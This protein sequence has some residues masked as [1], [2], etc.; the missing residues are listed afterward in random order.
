M[1]DSAEVPAMV[2]TSSIRVGLDRPARLRRP[3]LLVFVAL[4]AF[5][6]APVLAGSC[7]HSMVFLPQAVLAGEWWRLLTAVLLLDR[8]LRCRYASPGVQQVFGIHHTQFAGKTLEE[9]GLPVPHVRLWEDAVSGVFASGTSREMMV[10]HPW[11]GE[12]AGW[13]LSPVHTDNYVSSGGWSVYDPKRDVFW[14]NGGSGGRVF[15]AF[16]PSDVG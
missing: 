6:N 10:R 14:A 12:T 16:D 7:F 9:A 11:T 1:S 15:V 5:F 3:E 4:L 2:E 8:D 13:R